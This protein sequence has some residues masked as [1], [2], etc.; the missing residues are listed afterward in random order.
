ML[1]A[2]WTFLQDQRAKVSFFVMFT[3][4]TVYYLPVGFRAFALGPYNGDGHP[5]IYT[6]L[7]YLV[8]A[9]GYWLLPP[10]WNHRQT[11]RA[12]Q[13]AAAAEEEAAE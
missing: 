6:V 5:W 9:A 7:L 1:T 3:A 13:Q 4:A 8:C 11:R 12:D 10:V 2:F